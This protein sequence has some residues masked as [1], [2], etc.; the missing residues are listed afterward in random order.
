MREKKGDERKPS[1]KK[2]EEMGHEGKRDE[3][4]EG[5]RERRK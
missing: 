1:I 5:Q 4:R 3:N 2:G